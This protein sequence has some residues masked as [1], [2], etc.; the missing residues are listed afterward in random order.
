MNSS[1]IDDV[2]DILGCSA[3]AAQHYLNIFD[4]DK[5]RAIQSVVSY[6]DDNSWWGHPWNSE[7]P[8]VEGVEEEKEVEVGSRDIYNGGS[9]DISMTS[10]ENLSMIENLVSETNNSN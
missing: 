5:S 9:D 4:N 6:G 1:D 8:K 7:N 3:L 10:D 2:K